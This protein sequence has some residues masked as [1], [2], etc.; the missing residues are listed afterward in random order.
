MI[1]IL[2]PVLGRPQNAAPL[3]E[4]IRAHT[5]V[6]YTI[7]FLCSWRDLDEMIACHDTG[8]DVTE[9]LFDAGPGDYAMKINAG[10][11]G[12]TSEFIFNAADDIEFTDGWAEAALAKM[13]DGIGVVATNDKANRQVMRGEFGTHCLIRRTYIEAYGGTG[14]NQPGVVMYEGYDHNYVDVELCAVA[15]ARGAYAFAKDS[16]VRHRHPLWR[17]AEWD[18]TYKRG[19]AGARADH[20]LHLE[21]MKLWH[22]RN[23]DIIAR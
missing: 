22:P 3:V 14:D 21:R 16:I 15:K 5:T 2:V 20:K 10:F 6:P 19:M 7:L 23:R 4:S 8:A 9:M 11:M 13:T 17:T 12:T 18:A 1:D